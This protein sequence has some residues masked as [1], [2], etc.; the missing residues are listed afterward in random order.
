MPLYVFFEMLLSVNPNPD[1]AVN[2]YPTGGVR[3]NL[4]Y[5]T[6]FFLAVA[7]ISYFSIAAIRNS[8][9]RVKI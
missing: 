8:T 1:L 3:T 7:F 9:D 5:A 6:K 4:V 2:S